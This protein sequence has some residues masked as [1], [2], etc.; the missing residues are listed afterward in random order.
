MISPK[1]Y[2]LA[3]A[4]IHAGFLAATVRHLFAPKRRSLPSAVLNDRRSRHEQLSAIVQ[5]WVK[6]VE[7]TPYAELVPRDLPRQFNE[8]SALT[9]EQS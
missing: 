7:D 3:L 8:S 6:K 1:I 2:W 4:I 9:T 5:H